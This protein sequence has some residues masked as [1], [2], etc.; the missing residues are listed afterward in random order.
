MK[1]TKYNVYVFLLLPLDHV[2]KSTCDSTIIICTTNIH[3]IYHHGFHTIIAYLWSNW[4][5]V[6]IFRC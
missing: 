2:L 6:T 4:P 5:T 3:L 1:Y